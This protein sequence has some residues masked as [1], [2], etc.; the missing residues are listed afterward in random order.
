MK[1]TDTTPAPPI[2][3]DARIG[4]ALSILNWRPRCGLTG[5]LAMKAMQG[6]SIE[7][8]MSFERAYN[9]NAKDAA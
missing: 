3:W 5:L 7:A 8:L 9:T 6:Y 4:L 1:A 2:N